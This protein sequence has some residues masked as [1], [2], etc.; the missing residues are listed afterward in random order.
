LFLHIG[1]VLIHENDIK[2]C[3]LLFVLTANVNSLQ[4]MQSRLI[5]QVTAGALEAD[6]HFVNVGCED[7]PHFGYEVQEGLKIHSSSNCCHSGGTSLIVGMYQDP[8]L[9]GCHSRG[10]GLPVFD[11]HL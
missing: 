10:D 9:L 1:H 2:L 4:P 11:P 5:K 7:V 3:S 8:T 6:M